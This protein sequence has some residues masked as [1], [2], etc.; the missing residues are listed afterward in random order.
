MGNNHPL[1]HSP[2][3]FSAQLQRAHDDDV[4]FGFQNIHLEKVWSRKRVNQACFWT[5]VRR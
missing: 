5:R 3:G 2:T 4:H 1:N